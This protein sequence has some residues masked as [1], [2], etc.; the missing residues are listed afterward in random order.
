MKHSASLHIL[1]V[2]SSFDIEHGVLP[3]LSRLGREREFEW[4]QLSILVTL[5]HKLNL[6][7][8]KKNNVEFLFY[9]VHL[10]SIIKNFPTV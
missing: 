1:A 5:T 2:G 4:T 9:S 10:V 8:Q 7:R 6:N 3:I